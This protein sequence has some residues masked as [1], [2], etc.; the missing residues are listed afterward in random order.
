MK[1][2]PPSIIMW[3]QEKHDDSELRRKWPKKTDSF[4]KFNRQSVT[5]IIRSS[6]TI[7]NN[8]LTSV[9]I[10][11]VWSD[12]VSYWWWSNRITQIERHSLQSKN[13]KKS[14]AGE[15]SNRSTNRE[16]VCIHARVDK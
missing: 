3:M 1:G 4:Q 14:E 5:N 8:C 16:S 2:R 9:H 13:A 7:H 10:T 11:Q 12:L 15:L 6:H